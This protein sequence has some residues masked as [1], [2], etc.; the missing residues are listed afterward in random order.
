MIR[1]VF[2]YSTYLIVFIWSSD[3]RSTVG[4]LPLLLQ[5]GPPVVSNLCSV[6]Y[7][8]KGNPSFPSRFQKAGY[9]TGKTCRSTVQRRDFGVVPRNHVQ[10][11]DGDQTNS[12]FWKCEWV[13]NTTQSFEKLRNLHSAQFV[14]PQSM[15]R[16]VVHPSWSDGGSFPAAF[17]RF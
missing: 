1:P 15:W 4:I 10:T 2:P 5:E 6:D 9:D 14:C 17:S 8:W 11:A 13:T 7:L 16:S 12:P 3:T